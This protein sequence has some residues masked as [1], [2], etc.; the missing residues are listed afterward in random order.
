MARKSGNGLVGFVVRHPTAANLVMG[1]M[2]LFGLF[3]LT[4]LNTQFF[5]TIETNRITVSVPWSGASAED[6]EDSILESLEPALRDLDQLDNIDSYA[7]EGSATIVLEFA[8][9]ADMQTAL[10]D[11]ESAIDTVTT[12]PESAD[13]VKASLRAWRE[14]VANI[15]IAGPF[16]EE[17]LK[18]YARRIRTTLLDAGIDTVTFTGLRDREIVVTTQQSALSR[19][20][21]T[22]QEMAGRIREQTQ[23]APSGT[24]D[25]T[26]TRQLR[27]LSPEIDARRIEEIDI[28]AL[29]TGERVRIGDV[30]DV[31]T[32]YDDE[33]QG[34][35]G[36]R[37]AIQLTVQRAASADTLETA[38][39]LQETLDEL[40]P[41]LPESLI[42]QVYDVR[43]DSLV[44][45]IALLTN[46]G[47]QGLVLVLVI[48]FVFLSARIA[49]WVAVGIPV[50]MIATLGVMAMTGSSIN[51]ISL[52][53]MIMTLGI[54]VDDAIVVGEHTATR[55]AAGDDPLLAAERGA[56]T[57][58]FPVVAATLTTQAAFLPLLFISGTIGQIMA[59]LP[60][61][62]LAVL[63]ASLV[64]CFLVLP[65]HLRHV[66][67]AKGPNRFRRTFDRGFG[68][69]R[70]GPFRKAATL[71]VRWRYTTVALAAASLIVAAGFLM[72]GRVGF[73]FFPS[74]EP[75]S[76][77]ANV[78]FAAGTPEADAI[79]AL[80]V[81]E[82]ALFDTETALSPDAPLVVNVF[83]E[84]GRSGR[85]TGDNL[86]RL[87]VQLT[88]A[89]DRDILT[90]DFSSAWRKAI[91]DIPGV[92]RVAIAGNRSGPPGRDV[93]I[94]LT[95]ASTAVL[96]EAA[97][98]VRDAI[99]TIEGVSAADDDLPFG[100]PELVLELTPRGAAL[101]FTTETVGQQVR[102][103]FEGRIARRFADGEEEV[104]IRVDLAQRGSG[105][106][107]LYALVLRAPSGED[108]ALPEIV[109]LRERR[110]FLV[111]QRRGG[112][113]AVS[114]TADLNADITTTEKV[115]AA[116]DDG[117]MPRIAA[118]YGI[119]YSF[120]GR[121]E[122]R[123]EAFADLRVGV[124]I[125]LGLIY[126]ILAWIFGSYGR[127]LAVM[128]IIPFGIVG[129]IF[130]HW[131]M[132]FPL[133]IL[134]LMGLLGLSGIL[135]NDSIILV[136][137]YQDRRENGE[138]LYTASI[139]ASQDR[140]RA[141]V[142]TSLTT[143]AGLS[144]LL[145]EKSLQAQFLIPMALTLVFGLAVAT[146][147]VLFLVPAFVCIGGDIVRVVGGTWRW[148]GF[149]SAPPELRNE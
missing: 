40:L 83:T 77:T 100:K 32:A 67:P 39:T 24:L 30:A 66:G 141:V 139:G 76:I 70:D 98:E 28:R 125:A 87:S 29:S 59:S 3:G 107:S 119:D 82:A 71:A 26:V 47:I 116:L 50:A 23:D 53:A 4:Q 36:G 62:V 103:A 22:L 61:V 90:R 12:L 136:E 21:L 114:V 96:K 5:P 92:E 135:V 27:T 78:T 46:N 43:A 84:L 102:D 41:T 112:V 52:F 133:T 15:M 55:L 123:R 137:R 89:E 14:T 19:L 121:D 72:S 105:L 60:L 146:L 18:S 95:G 51:M 127:P 75:E 10:R 48:L 38:N 64:E 65:G 17:A 20:D 35:T 16:E 8:S 117:L 109:D 115:V 11:V 128:L 81:I 34:F 138:D 1:L 73:Q 111:I 86:A 130:G 124:V 79:A 25:G 104:T 2:I 31:V 93:D 108:V 118:K 143:V 142:L 131:L 99:E 122:E 68:A 69:F 101:G 148:L 106:A 74:P 145:F 80:G 134:S 144:P 88:Q 37:R 126:I 85:A 45:R 7:R 94:R 9:D 58:L 113:T 42:V 140:L 56:G 63:T 44:E 129:A 54:I 110:G 13:D 149:G 132:G 147:F 97:L 57:M 49:F 6:V 120:S 91:P 33:P